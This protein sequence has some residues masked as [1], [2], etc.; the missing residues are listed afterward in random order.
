[1]TLLTHE[2][3]T[4]LHTLQLTFSRGRILW[5]NSRPTSYVSQQLRLSVVQLHPLLRCSYAP[6][7][8]DIGLPAHITHTALFSM[9]E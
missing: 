6:Q 9:N 1:V 5:F 2:T 3:G 4:A 7:C 8:G